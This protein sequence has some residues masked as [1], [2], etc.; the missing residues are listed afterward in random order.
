[1]SDE[2]TREKLLSSAKAEFLEKGYAKASL[3]KI[4]ADAGVTTGA[5]YFLFE[6]KEDLFGAIAEPPLKALQELLQSHF[7]YDT[8]AMSQP[9]IHSDGDH[10][11]F[12]AALVHCIYS[13]YDAFIL[14]LTKS[15]GTKYENCVDTLVDTIE[16]FYLEMSELIGKHFG[17]TVNRYMLHWLIH[18]IIDS[19]IHLIRHER[20]E[21]K[22]LAHMKKI[23]DLFTAGWRKAVLDGES[24]RV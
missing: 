20:S 5:V 16:Q 11:D 3:R 2:E 13:N 23:M 14:L 18:M 9:Y 15:Q 4:C 1:M 8:E 21:E 12:T 19:F 17:G 6:D 24:P 7:A 10:D 22:A